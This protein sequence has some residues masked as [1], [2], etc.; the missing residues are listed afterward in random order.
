MKMKS[1][2]KAFDDTLLGPCVGLVGQPVASHCKGLVQ[3]KVS[4]IH[5]LTYTLRS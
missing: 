5:Q 3:S 4:V 1:D 2:E